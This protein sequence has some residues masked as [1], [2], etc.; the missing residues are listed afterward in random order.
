MFREAPF[1]EAPVRPPNPA[2]TSI[3]TA[4]DLQVLRDL[5][6]ENVLIESARNGIRQSLPESG[7][8][9]EGLRSHFFMP[10]PG[11]PPE[12]YREFARRREAQ[13]ITLFM[14]QARGQGLFLSIHFYWGLMMGLSPEN[15]VT[16]VLL[17]GMYGGIH[18]L[19]AGQQTLTRT[20]RYLK[21]R[22]DQG[23]GS[24]S[25]IVSGMSTLAGSLLM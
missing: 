23:E 8:F 14:V 11:Q 19:N 21:E 6:D 17:V 25:E 4:Q 20:F 5:F 9:I 3:L 2:I 13:L 10:V 24:T 12:E 22:V 7:W 1:N 15:I 16:H 18:I